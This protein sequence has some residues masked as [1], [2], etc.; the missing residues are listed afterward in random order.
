[1]RQLLLALGLVDRGGNYESVRNRIHDLGIDDSYLRKAYVQGRPLA[2]CSDEEIAAAVAASRSLREVLLK[3]SVR[4]GGNQTRLGE[5]IRELELDTTHFL[6]QGW[7]KGRTHPVVP[8]RPIQEVLI[9]GSFVKSS[10]L[11]MRLLREGIKKAQCE[12][13]GRAAWNGRPIPLEL[14]HK[15]GRRNDNRLANIRLLCPNCH[16]QTPTYRGRNIGQ[17][18]R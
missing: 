3:L 18:S 15:N 8:A 12:V 1:M 9:E 7:Q 11:R 5:R 14:D 17:L 10:H 13:C 6:G 16:A 2:K 4:L